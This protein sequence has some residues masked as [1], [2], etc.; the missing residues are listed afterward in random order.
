[1][2]ED[3]QLRRATAG[4][5]ERIAEIYNWYVAN[6][7]V[8]FETETVSAHQMAERITDKLALFDW[9]VG[10]LNQKIV[11]YAYYGPFRQ[12]AAYFRT[13]ESTVYLSRDSKGKG[14]GREI[15]FAAI[16]SAS[17]KGFRELIGVIAL[18]NPASLALH[19]KLG[20]R[21]AGILRR[22]GYKFGEFHDI[23]IWQLSV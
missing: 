21:E 4:D 8:T 14:F 16:D 10:E 19:A 6:T 5:A 18:P 9:I 23:A 1:V 17:Q 11:G 20:F 12:R 7:V 2:S 15:Y 13:V 3:L 22:V